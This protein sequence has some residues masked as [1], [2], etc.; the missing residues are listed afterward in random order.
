MIGS[1]L[2][3]VIIQ[4]FNHELEGRLNKIPELA[5][6]G[7]SSV[8]IALIPVTSATSGN[9]GSQVTSTLTRAASLGE[10][11]DAKMSK[12]ILKE[13]MVGLTLGSILSIV[14]YV[15][16]LIYYMIY[17][18]L[19]FKNPLFISMI[20]LISSISL[21]ISI[22]LSKLLGATILTIAIKTKNDP[23]VMSAPLITTIIDALSTLIFFLLSY[24]VLI[25][26]FQI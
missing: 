2:S 12:I 7:I 17:N 4:I 1:T 26:V 9:A 21:L 25:P 19:L 24:A 16:L 11:K 10:L 5:N 15:R 3:Q 13:S 18:G 6:V 23:A 14:N 8:L 22:T 20:S